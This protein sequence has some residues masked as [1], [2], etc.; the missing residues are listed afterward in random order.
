MPCTYT[1]SLGLP[2]F[3][4]TAYT[5]SPWNF[6][7]FWTKWRITGNEKL[8]PF[9]TTCVTLALAIVF[10]T[11]Q[12]PESKFFDKMQQ[13]ALET[14]GPGSAAVVVRDGR[15]IFLKA[16]GLADTETK[17]KFATSTAF[18]IGSISKQFVATA[19]L[20]LVAERKL[21]LT[22]PLGKHL[23]ELPEAWRSATIEQTLHHMSGIPDYE[24]IAGYDYYNAPRSEKDV[25]DQAASKAPEFKPGDRW[26]YS[27]TGYYLLS[28]IV[29]KRSGIP[30]GQFLEERIF[31]PLGM[32]STY[33]QTMPTKRLAATGYH[34]RSGKQTAQPPI[35]WSSTYGAGG[36]VSTL[37]DMTLWDNALYTEKLLPARLRDM[38]WSS[39]K[40]NA[41][42]TVNYGF[43]WFTGSYRDIPRQDHGGQTNGFTCYYYRFPQHRMAIFAVTNT[44][45][46]RVGSMANA[47]A[48]HFV[49][50]ASFYSLPAVSGADAERSKTHLA[51]LKQAVLGEGGFD[52]V[53]EGIKNF[54]TEKS[55]EAM[56][57]PLKPSLGS[58]KSFQLVKE[59]QVKMANGTET[60]EFTY[61]MESADGIRFWVFRVQDGKMTF[62]SWGDE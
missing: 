55:F 5:D 60:P 54:A 30:V 52:L 31:R 61:R 11:P 41:G 44:Y 32:T 17:K 36:I 26:D 14:T 28:M 3:K 39:A 59:K 47:L 20:M 8:N 19:L 43:G 57:E 51:M 22:D 6:L 7:T 12:L 38:L 24:A 34:S 48:A 40:T 9:I 23:P 15:P 62:L 21:S 2:C 56:R 1:L 13:L 33:A 42:D 37:S 18:E 50:G 16:Y 46:G 29:A 25:I 58:M 4:E 45:G 49:P 27:N 53:S 35:A 10:A